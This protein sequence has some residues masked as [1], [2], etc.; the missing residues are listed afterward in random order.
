MNDVTDQVE[1][2]MT[3]LRRGMRPGGRR[4]FARFLALSCLLVLVG[5]IAGWFARDVTGGPRPTA[6]RAWAGLSRDALSA[7][8][9]YAIEIAHPVEIGAKDEAHLGQWLTMR[10]KRRVVI[11]DLSDQFGLDLV[12]G[13]LLP[14]G[15]DVA[16]FLMYRDASGGRLTLYI[17][18]EP[19]GETALN[20]MRE[21]DVSTF[22]WIDDGTGYVV[23]AAMDR[24]RL[25]KIARAVSQEFDMEAVRRR[26]AL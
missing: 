19:R 26:R 9:A 24:E 6:G 15:P 25:Q 22:A 21:G 1:T 10:L 17:R 18:Q 23:V 8:R 7:H 13:R 12:G 3:A 5:G 4:R 2:R 16:A 11:P 20:F 14:A